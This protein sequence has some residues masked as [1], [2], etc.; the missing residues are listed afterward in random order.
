MESVNVDRGV[1]IVRRGLVWH[2]SVHRDGDR[3]RKSL[4]TRDRQRA[5]EIA[6]D[7][8]ASSLS[9]RWNV[10]VAGISLSKLF[11]DFKERESEVHHAKGTRLILAHFVERFVPWCEAQGIRTVDRLTREHVERFI[12]ERSRMIGE[13]GRKLSPAT[14]NRDLSWLHRILQWAYVRGIVRV[15]VV[16]GVRRFRVPHRVK[17]T[18][19]T[20]EI[21]KLAAASVSSTARDIIILLANT[22]LRI[23]E[24]LDVRKGDFDAAT[25]RLV[26][27]SPKVYAERAIP[28]NTAAL[29]VIARRAL[30]AQSSGLLFATEADKPI[31]RHNAA[32]AIRASAR[33][34]G[35]LRASPHALRRSFATMCASVLPALALQ[36]ILGHSTPSTTATFYVGSAVIGAP[37]PVVAI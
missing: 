15:N 18:L 6:R 5:L 35:I 19:T 26:V 4:K 27:R 33:K 2:L 23:G 20:E 13:T 30:S 9:G 21:G 16:D 7:L 1:S 34:A 25:Q 28:L 29:A 8:A 24:A 12:L 31:C 14:V 37:P 32:R 10:A 3:R 17:F 11:Q 22:G 36:K